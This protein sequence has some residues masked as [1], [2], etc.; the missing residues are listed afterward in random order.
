VDF[1]KAIDILKREMLAA[2]L[3]YVTG[4]D[5][6]ITRILGDILA[7]NYVQIDDDIAISRHITQTNG[8]L[9]GGSWPK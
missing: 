2:K 4:T 7:Y 9:Q 5:H 1:S 3:G 8:V 6:A